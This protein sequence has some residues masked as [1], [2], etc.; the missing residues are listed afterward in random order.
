MSTRGAT[1][2]GG[3]V[4][5]LLYFTLWYLPGCLLAVVVDEVVL[6]CTPASRVIASA[7]TAASR[8]PCLSPISISHWRL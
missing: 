8:S 3:G 7:V 2:P 1:S 5:A 4:R 6:T